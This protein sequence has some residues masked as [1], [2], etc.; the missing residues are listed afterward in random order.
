MAYGDFKYLPERAASD[1]ILCNK[2]FNIAKNT[3]HDGQK[4]GLALIV[5]RFLDKN[6]HVMVL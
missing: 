6:I 2:A 4:R 3:K 1:K 5:Y